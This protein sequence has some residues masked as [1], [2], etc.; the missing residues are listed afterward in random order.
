MR[1]FDSLSLV[2]HRYLNNFLLNGLILQTMYC[3]NGKMVESSC[4]Y[5]MTEIG[6]A[7]G[8]PLHGLRVQGS[9]RVPF[10]GVH[11]KLVNEKGALVSEK[12]ESGELRVK[13]LQLFEE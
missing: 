7:L 3:W 10:P 11:V 9:V 1:V 5:G 8:N 6:M 13:S 2:L 4:R 12:G